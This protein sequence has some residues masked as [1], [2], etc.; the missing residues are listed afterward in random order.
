MPPRPPRLGQKRTGDE[1][2]E[3]LS[4][5]ISR[6]ERRLSTIREAKEALAREARAEA[7]RVRAAEEA[8][9]ARH[10]E[11]AREAP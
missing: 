6:R 4:G 1:L 11:D 9:R 8:E 3:G 10:A 2:P 5:E 7:E